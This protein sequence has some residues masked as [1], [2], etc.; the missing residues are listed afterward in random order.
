MTD[1]ICGRVGRDVVSAIADRAAAV[2]SERRGAW[3]VCLAPDG[4]VTVENPAHVIPED[5]LGTW[6]KEL[7]RI[8]LW[9]EIEDEL[10]DAIEARGIKGE[11][12]YRKRVYGGR[13]RKVA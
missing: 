5:W 8:G 6:N 7:G 3:A 12:K 4:F 2:I 10:K 9:R 11:I 13:V 1:T